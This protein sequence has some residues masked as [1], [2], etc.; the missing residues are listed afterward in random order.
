MKFGVQP[1]RFTVIVNDGAGT[2][3]T[4]CAAGGIGAGNFDWMREW[5]SGFGGT[6]VCFEYGTVEPWLPDRPPRRGAERDAAEVRAVADKSGATRAVG[7]SRGT[8]AVAG[9]LAED[10]GRFDRVVLV[11]PAAGTAAGRYREWL[12]EL[13]PDAR[14]AVTG[15]D[16]LI[17]AM[18]GDTGHPVKVAEDWASRLGAQLEVF[19]SAYR[20]PNVLDVMRDRSREFLE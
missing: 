15:A 20:M 8:F 10:P 4:V 12:M 7:V 14:T 1:Y 11:I 18:R 3:T 6:R 13:P 5:A 16:I 9:V 2:P 19:Q 17:L